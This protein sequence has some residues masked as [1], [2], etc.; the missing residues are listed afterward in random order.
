[1][2][3][4]LGNSLWRGVDLFA[5]IDPNEAVT[6]RSFYSYYLLVVGAATIGKVSGRVTINIPV[7]G[8]AAAFGQ[9]TRLLVSVAGADV[10][11]CAMH[12]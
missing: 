6:F 5:K 8:L 9:E 1:V 7:D 12:G 10:W 3:Y 4:T 11:W 2:A